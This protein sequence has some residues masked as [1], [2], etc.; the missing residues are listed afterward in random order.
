MGAGAPG[1]A[2]GEVG[3]KEEVD[4]HEEDGVEAA[5][6][7]PEGVFLGCWAITCRGCQDGPDEGRRIIPGALASSP[8]VGWE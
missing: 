1:A 8:A 6:P 3:V 7:G 2:S 5:D 4:T